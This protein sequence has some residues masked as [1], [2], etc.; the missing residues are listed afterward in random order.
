MDERQSY[1]IDGR[2]RFWGGLAVGTVD[3]GEGLMER[4]RA[5]AARTGIDVRHGIDPSGRLRSVRQGRPRHDR[6]LAAEVQ[7]GAPDRHAAIRRVP[8]HV[9]DHVH[10]RRGP[11]RR[12]GAC[13]RHRG[14]RHPRT[15]R[16]GRARRRPVSTTTRAA[17]G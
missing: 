5:A 16:G 15:R 7:L 1:E 8:R 2:H 10:V 3:G 13:A 14:P 6:D 4:H 9:R 12:A 17:A 11:R